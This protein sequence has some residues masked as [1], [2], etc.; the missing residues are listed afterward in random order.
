[1]NKL[2]MVAVAARLALD[3]YEAIHAAG[4]FDGEA[5][6]EELFAL[7]HILK[8]IEQECDWYWQEMG[9]FCADAID[10]LGPDDAMWVIDGV[11]KFD[12]STQGVLLNGMRQ[13]LGRTT[14]LKVAMAYNDAS[15][16]WRGRF[17]L[18]VEQG[19][20]NEEA[21]KLAEGDMKWL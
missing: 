14:A 13:N 16:E 8:M 12:A 10:D 21:M 3:E 19:K 1:M 11:A 20:N 6:P 7:A 15:Y 18:H 17:D 2:D 5:T 9:Q 4:Y